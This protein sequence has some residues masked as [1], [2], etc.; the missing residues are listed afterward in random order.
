MDIAGIPSG[1]FADKELGFVLMRF[2]F[3]LRFGVIFRAV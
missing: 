3:F 2:P 1:V